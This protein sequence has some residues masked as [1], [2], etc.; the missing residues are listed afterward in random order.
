MR[1]HLTT[2]VAL[3]VGSVVSGWSEDKP[4]HQGWSPI[5][6]RVVEDATGRPVAGARIE[7]T[8]RGCIYAN[9]RSQTDTN[10]LAKVMVFEKWVLLKATK[11]D[12]TN[13]V[14]LL[15]SNAVAGFR[16]NAVIRL[17]KASR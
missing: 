17:K 12:L 8:C 2:L 14:S 3:L 11:D 15:G 5:Q 13:S 6:V 1:T 7:Q 4:P 10:G 16:T 9:E